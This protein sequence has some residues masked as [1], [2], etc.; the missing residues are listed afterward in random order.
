MRNCVL[1][2][3]DDVYIG[4]VNPDTAEIIDPQTG[5]DVGRIDRWG[6]VFYY[7]DYRATEPDSDDDGS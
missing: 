5:I 2:T 7:S 4:V 3:S 1:E 6:N